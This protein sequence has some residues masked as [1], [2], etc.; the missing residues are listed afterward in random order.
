MWVSR[1]DLEKYDWFQLGQRAT[2]FEG[3]RELEYLRAQVRLGFEVYAFVGEW[4]PDTRTQAPGFCKLMDQA[5]LK[6]G[7]LQWIHLGRDK[8]FLP[9]TEQFQIKKIPTFIFLKN[10]KEIGR[11]VETPRGSLLEDSA[12][13]LGYT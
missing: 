13:I 2:S 4:C 5:G 3:A 12:Q 7:A 8:K 11:I 1:A 10:G 6:E 9:Y